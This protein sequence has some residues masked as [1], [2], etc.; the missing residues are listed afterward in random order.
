MILAMLLVAP[1]AIAGVALMAAGLCRA[2]NA[3]HGIMAALCAA[4]TAV[5]AWVAIGYALFAGA[6]HTVT[7]AGRAWNWIGC[8]PALMRGAAPDERALFGLLAAALAAVIPLSSGAERWR[9]GAICGSSAVFGGVVVPLFAHW[10]WGGG[11]LAGLGFVDA[12]GAGTIH[13]AGGMAGLAIAWTLGPRRGKYTREGLPV[14]FPGH[15]AV[16]VLLGCFLAWIGWLGMNGAGAAL[17][18]GSAQ[19]AALDT[20]VSACAAGLAAAAITRLRFGKADASL[21]ANGW[22]AGLVA[23]SAGCASMTPAGVM[24]TGVVAGA[25]TPYAI[26]LFEARAFVDDPGGA[27]VTH[28][29]A[30]LWGLA[31]AALFGGAPGIAQLAGAATVVGFVL[32]LMYGVD[33]AI[34]GRAAAD[35]ERRGMDLDELGAGAYPDF[36][37]HRD[38]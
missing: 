17:A 23:A 31:A 38:D 5:L 29:I 21:T 28:G 24:L 15:S 4:A 9:L 32:P 33:Y 35:A 37:T 22:T 3:A 7:I 36:P 13:A 20:T 34:G 18:G 6:G 11:W 19:A 27:V 16:L 12:G 8:G 10:S 14:A 30:G 1:C 26:E 25:M 2:R